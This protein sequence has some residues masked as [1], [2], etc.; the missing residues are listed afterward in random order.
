[1]TNT[2]KSCAHHDLAEG[3]GP[4]EIEKHE[5][6]HCPQCDIR[7]E[8]SFVR[9]EY[10]GQYRLGQFVAVSYLCPLGHQWSHKFTR[11]DKRIPKSVPREAI[12]LSHEVCLSC[13]RYIPRR[14][15]LH[16]ERRAYL[17]KCG[18][19]NWIEDCEIR[20][21]L[22]PCDSERC[23]EQATTDGFCIHHGANE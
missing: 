14:V 15:L 3:S 1:M 20:Q 21:D 16:K 17:C 6:D 4:H 19:T 12:P 10:V 9:G 18:F 23:V 8:A 13:D 5:P 7:P 22:K 11:G 2:R